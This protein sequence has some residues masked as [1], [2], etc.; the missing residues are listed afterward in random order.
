MLLFSLFPDI[1]LWE[2]GEYRGDYVLAST[3]KHS[4]QS[5]IVGQECSSQGPSQLMPRGQARLEE[6]NHKGYMSRSPAVILVPRRLTDH[7]IASCTV[8]R[9]TGRYVDEEP[10]LTWQPRAFTGT[11]GHLS[12]LYSRLLLG[13]SS[14][15]GFH[16]S[17][18]KDGDFGAK[19]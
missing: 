6:A 1:S 2:G 3:A 15:L 4:P 10:F 17:G 19:I 7:W 8:R 14:A 16:T 18:A 12:G 11:L 9:G 13:S 5:E